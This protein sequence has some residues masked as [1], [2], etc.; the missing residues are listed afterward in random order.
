MVRAGALLGVGSLVAVMAAAPLALPLL[1][2]LGFAGVGF[3]S[4]SMFPVM[5]GA[6]ASRPGIPSGHGVAITTWLVRIGLVIAPAII[7]AAADAWGLAAALGISL[8]AS[9]VIL[10]LAPVLTGSSGRRRVAGPS[11][12]R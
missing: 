1:A 9:A 5:I 6:A 3:G 12:A 2:F 11:P 10:A 7:G 4:S 8:V